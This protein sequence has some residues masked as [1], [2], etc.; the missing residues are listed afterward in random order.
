MRK[1]KPD[2][3]AGKTAKTESTE[4]S[5]VKSM[6]SLDAFLVNLADQDA[7]RFV[8]V[9]FRL[10]LDDVKSGEE[11]GADPVILAA[12][13]DKI[14]SILSTKTAETILTPEGKEQLRKE[15]GE[16]VNPI[17]PKGKI[18]EVFIMDFVVQL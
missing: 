17:L 11:Y 1:L 4:V 2:L 3:S 6:M 10:G 16:K 9:T 7:T 13:R 18:V 5:K 14:I 12:T 8:K 15:I